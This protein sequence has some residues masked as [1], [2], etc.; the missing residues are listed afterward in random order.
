MFGI[1]YVTV[2]K[3]NG[4]KYIGQHKC[5]DENDKYL[6][7]G[8]TLKK[9]IEKYGKENFNRITLYRAET[10]EELDKK[11]I[12]FIAAF[13]A[14]E[15]NDYYNI[16]EGGLSYRKM[17]GVN[18]PSF[19]KR[20]PLSPNY[21]SKRSEATKQKMSK[22]QKGHPSN[23]TEEMK[24]KISKTMKA[25]GTKPCAL[26]Y[27]RLKGKKGYSHAGRPHK[28]VLCIELGVVFESQSEIERKLGIP[29][30]N[31]YKVLNGIRPKAGGYTFAYTES[32]VGPYDTK[33]GSNN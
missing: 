5:S 13:R 8:K 33:D 3:V 27:Q 4:K 12:E 20:G 7:S 30:A 21:G 22:S 31:I 17:V 26:A 23:M 32:E 16:T 11:E 24:K 14:T 28:H 19:G 9:A 10:E 6:G 15:R 29:Q 1:V 18:N 2:N 25:H